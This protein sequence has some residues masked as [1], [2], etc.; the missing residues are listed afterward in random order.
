MAVPAALFLLTLA[1]AHFR[2]EGGMRFMVVVA[3]LLAAVRGGVLVLAYDVGIADPGLTV[4]ALVPAIVVG[5]VVGVA[6]KLRPRLAALPRP[7]V[8]GWCLIAGVAAINF[9]VQTVGLKLFGIGIAQYLVYPTLAIVIWPLARE[10]DVRR[11]SRVIVGA[12]GLVAV[13]VMLQAMGVEFL[14]AAN[15]RVD[16]L[17]ADRFAGIT[18]SYLHTSAFV[19]AAFVVATCESLGSRERRE[20]VLWALVMTLLFSA[21]IMT[22]SRSGV[23]IAAI[24]VG[25]AFLFAAGGRRLRVLATVVPVVLVSV[26]IGAIGGVSPDAAGERAA[27]GLSPSNDA[28]N[29]LRADAI[30]EGIDAYTEGSLKE[31]LLGTGLAGTGNAGQLDSGISRIVESYYLKVL[32]ET[33]ALGLIFIGGFLLWSLSWFGRVML[34]RPEPLAAGLAGAG[35]GLGLYNV[36]YPALETQLLAMAWWLVFSLSLMDGWP[37]RRGEKWLRI[38]V[39]PDRAD[40]PVE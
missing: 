7:L 34:S 39:G 5:L 35:L 16:G 37:S 12:A 19:G 21:V 28:G 40:A 8:I 25:A 1:A 22:F 30:D 17:A 36:I 29:Q 9:L 23:M 15:A 20:Q 6:W 33:G 11:L 38:P 27:S 18:G 24:G 4:N 26:L 31:K 13:T 2:G 3:V 14:Q 32:T 10:G